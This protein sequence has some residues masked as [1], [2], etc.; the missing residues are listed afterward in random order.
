[1]ITIAVY[2]HD[3]NS[4]WKLITDYRNLDATRV[5]SGIGALS[6]TL[7]EDQTAD[8][9]FQAD[10]RL[11]LILSGDDN[12]YSNIFGTYLLGGW[13]WQTL[14]H[15][16]Y[17]TLKALCANSLLSRRIVAYAAGS[18]QAQKTG[19]ADDLMR[20][21]VRENL[22]SSAGTGRNISAYGLSVEADLSLAS[23]ITMA[24]AWRNV[25][26]VINDLVSSAYQQ[27]G[28]RLLWDTRPDS[29]GWSVV[30]A[31]RK[32]FFRDR[33]MSSPYA[34]WLS[35]DND[36]LESVVESYDR[37]DAYNIVYAGGQ[38][39]GSNRVIVTASDSA[40]MAKSVIARSESFYDG[41]QYSDLTSLTAAANGR[42]QYGKPKTAV[43]AKLNEGYLIHYGRDIMIGDAL[44][45]KA[46]AE[47][48]MVLKSAH[49]TSSE[50]VTDIDLTLEEII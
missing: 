18:A 39:T 16:H 4:I 28:D 10:T 11:A 34:L 14:G 44:T 26:D 23:S 21:V 41:S 5:I 47:Y 24:F 25:Y 17:V 37:R 13:E 27:N 19:A 30:F 2:R 43:K 35:A 6:L 29:D 9:P 50:G 12:S 3:S 7:S 40:E 8:I 31:V 48:D 42:L 45:I 38:G 46:R 15:E 20:A 49:L 36:T 32:D 1:M 33:R 22:G